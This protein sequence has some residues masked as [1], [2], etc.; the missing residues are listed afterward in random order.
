M[1][2]L[3]GFVLSTGLLLAAAED[4][5]ISLYEHVKQPGR[6]VMMLDG[7]AQPGRS[8]KVTDRLGDPQE[9]VFAA[10][11][12]LGIFE[13]G[14]RVPLFSTTKLALHIAGEHNLKLVCDGQTVAEAKGPRVEYTVKAPA[15]CSAQVFQGDQL[16]IESEPILL[17]R[18]TPDTLKLP[19]SQLDATVEAH[20]DIVYFEGDPAAAAKHK[21]DVYAPKTKP[22]AG[23]PVFIF[24]H[25]G[26][27]RSGDRAQYPPL[28]N[29]FAKAGAVVV[30]PSY[31]LAPAH[32]HPAQ[33]EDVAA[34]IAWTVKNVRAYGGDPSRIYLGGHSAGGHLV[35]LVALDPRYL[36]AHELK[37]ALFKG[38]IAMSGVY[39]VRNLENVFGKD[40]AA[41]PAASPLTYVRATAPPFM[42]TYCQ[43]DY[44]TLP[45]QARRF[46]AALREAGARSELV[47]VPAQNHISEVINAVKEDDLTAQSVLR[48]I[49]L[50]GG[51]PAPQQSGGS[52]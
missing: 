31:R 4:F 20:R 32:V 26:S 17:E 27:W 19:S 12:T 47:Y 24:I 37:P 10:S 28:G 42:V 43:W 22:E 40:P 46:H 50:P 30:I 8:Y 44:A 25:G 16:W 29:R 1:R 21:L 52:K 2:A 35:A 11:N 15:A 45:A 48:L 14:D 7:V 13:I 6:R 18:P 51:T 36:A 9:F 3:V 23:A 33:A 41:W 49:G 34:A 38:V 5:P 39:D